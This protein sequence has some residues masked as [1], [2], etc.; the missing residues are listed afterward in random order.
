MTS[1]LVCLQFQFIF[2]IFFTMIWLLSDIYTSVLSS[3][4][5]TY[6]YVFKIGSFELSECDRTLTSLCF[7][8]NSIR[9]NHM[10]SIETCRL[11][12]LSP[13]QQMTIWQTF[14]SAFN[15]V[16]LLPEIQRIRNDHPDNPG[17]RGNVEKLSMSCMFAMCPLD[18]N[19]QGHLRNCTVLSLSL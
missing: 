12:S 14:I 16:S 13:C 10:H 6:S 18:V 15:V 5:F 4:A 2:I 7:Y 17:V 3:T 9:P 1:H 19:S 11:S 8:L